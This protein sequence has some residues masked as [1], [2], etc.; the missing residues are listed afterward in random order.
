M[1]TACLYYQDNCPHTPNP[2]QAD[3]DDDGVG[4]VCDLDALHERIETLESQVEA[5]QTQI[6]NILSAYEAL[7]VRTQDL[8]SDMNTFSN[9]RHKY[10]TGKVKGH[11]NTESYTGSPE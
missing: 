11:N 5:L 8:Q 1:V 3:S 9:H 7:E 6:T 2:D 4:D 10:M